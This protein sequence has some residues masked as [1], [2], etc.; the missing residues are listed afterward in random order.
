MSLA[1]LSLFHQNEKTNPMLL[2]N[3]HNLILSFN[4]AFMRQF[5]YD[6]T[7]IA[8]FFLWELIFTKENRFDNLL[9]LKYSFEHILTFHKSGEISLS[10][11]NSYPICL[12]GSRY[13]VLEI[14]D[15]YN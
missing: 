1:H 6:D 5:G 10:D 3:K 4:K 9:Q 2:V 8:N 14:S 11:F 13:A 15:S 7:Y 12:L